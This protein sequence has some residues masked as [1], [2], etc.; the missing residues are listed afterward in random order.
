MKSVSSS[1]W[2]IISPSVRVSKRG[3]SVL[4]MAVWLAAC[5]NVP[6]KYEHADVIDRQVHRGSEAL[7]FDDDSSTLVS[8]GW[9][10]ELALWPMPQGAP[11]VI[12]KGHDGPVHG[13]GFAGKWVVSAGQDGWIRVWDR[14]GELIREK[15]AGVAVERAAVSASMAVTGHRDGT[16]RGWSLPDLAV[17]MELDLHARE[18]KAVALN[19]QA[20]RFASVGR[21]HKVFLW[22]AAGQTRRFVTP[23][24][25][26]R[27]LAFS[28]DGKALYGGGWV[29]L[30]KWSV[31]DG[32]LVVLPTDHWGLI[33]G[34]QYV[35][36]L[37]VLATISRIND[38]SVYFLDPDT[39]KTVKTFTPQQLCGGAITMSPN[40]RYLATTG[41]DGA[42]RMWDLEVEGVAPPVVAVAEPN[43]TP[44][45]EQNPTSGW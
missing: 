9:E 22:D 3:V 26:V 41:D 30:F 42:V 21:D 36:T 44:G 8:G 35:E 24:G 25:M 28:A 40:G 38:S 5:T 12:W 19:P 11:S 6:S 16:V 17:S 4:A 31:A 1:I 2:R 20:T 34:I 15:D 32:R 37:N 18:V 45:P 33:S 10:G 27:S 14:R 23:P 43:L 39:G 7:D 29:D 13:L